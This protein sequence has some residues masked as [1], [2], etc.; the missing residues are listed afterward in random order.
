MNGMGT[1]R[2]NSKIDRMA[3]LL[4]LES[5]MVTN[6]SEHGFDKPQPEPTPD[7]A[8]RPGQRKGSAAKQ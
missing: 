3:S 7:R 6:R 1:P 4:Y 5:Q 2:N 8:T